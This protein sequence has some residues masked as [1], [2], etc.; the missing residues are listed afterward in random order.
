MRVTGNFLKNINLHTY[1]S[2][3]IHKVDSNVNSKN[4]KKSSIINDFLYNDEQILYK[5]ILFCPIRK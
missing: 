4:V 3:I 1:G 2:L 5:N